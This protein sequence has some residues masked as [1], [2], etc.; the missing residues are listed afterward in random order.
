MSPEGWLNL[1]LAGLLLFYACYMIWQAVLNMMCSQIGVD[2]CEYLSAG[3]AA[4]EHGYAAIYDPG[5]LGQAQRSLLPGAAV[6]VLPF[7]YLPIFVLPFQLL[8]RLSP[9]VGFWIWT[10]A[11]GVGLLLYL[12]LF[13]RSQG[14]QPVSNRLML[15]I[16][17]CLPVFMNLLT[18]QME[19][20][21]AIC[22]GEFMRAFAGHRSFQAGLWLGGL[23]L[24][25]QALILIV[26]LLLIQ[27]SWRTLAAF[28]TCSLILGGVSLLLASPSGLLQMFR[29]WLTT[30]NGQANIWLEGMMNWRMMGVHLASVL[31]PWPGWGIAAIGMLATFAISLYIWRRPFSPES[32]SFAVAWLGILAATL[33][34]TWHAHIHMAMILI[35]PLLYIYQAK[36]LPHR[37]LA[38]WVFLPAFVFVSMVFVPETLM[39][40]N[41]LSG[42]TRPLIY[43][44]ISASEFAVNL[45]LFMWAWL[46]FRGEGV[47]ATVSK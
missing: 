3:M 23:L 33:L 22:A 27:R 5:L 11:N 31:G 1:G 47:P 39:R 32:P 8:S 25:P 12:R 6:P 29:V 15:M 35:P 37:V 38:C 45:W 14:L 24:K 46:N 30:A 7:F 18:G 44:F 40:L 43:F 34:I 17:A 10:A 2:Y 21:L 42:D 13:V 4:N 16:F 36:I 19:L 9:E 26:P 28:G 20:W 41:I